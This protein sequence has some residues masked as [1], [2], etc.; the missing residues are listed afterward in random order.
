MRKRTLYT[1]GDRAASKIPTIIIMCIVLFCILY[2][3]KSMSERA[4]EIFVPKDPQID[5]QAQ[6]NLKQSPEQSSHTD[7]TNP[8]PQT[9][10]AGEIIYNTNKSTANS[11]LQV[12][13]SR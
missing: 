8:Q 2:F 1:Q 13:S 3:G 6:V 12:I 4:A 9:H 7:P 11:L 10:S 5:E